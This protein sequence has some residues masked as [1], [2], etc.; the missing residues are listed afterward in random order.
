MA[1]VL[2]MV[3]MVFM[4]IPVIAPSIGQIIMIFG[5]WSEIFLAMAVL[6]VP[7]M[8]LN[9][10]GHGIPPEN[11]GQA[12]GLVLVSLGNYGIHPANVAKLGGCLADGGRVDCN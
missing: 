7:V 4:V 8:A 6:A 1:E 10:A 5:D 12:G 2:S 3:M 11:E 9:K